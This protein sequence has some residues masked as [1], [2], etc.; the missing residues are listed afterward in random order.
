MKVKGRKERKNDKEK[1]NRKSNID[2]RKE[3]KKL[4]FW[5]S[6]AKY[7]GKDFFWYVRNFINLILLYQLNET[8]M[9]EKGWRV[10]KKSYPNE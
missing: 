2:K 6:R 1:K 10:I 5:N 9:E 3:R 7:K 8:W 4:I